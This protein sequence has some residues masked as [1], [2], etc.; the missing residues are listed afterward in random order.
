MTIPVWPSDLPQRSLSQAFQASTRGNRLTT[1][2]DT[3]PA[4]QRRRGPSVRPVTCAI[5][6]DMDGRALFD[7]FYEEGVGFGVT[8]F[9]IPDQQLDGGLL[10]DESWLL[11]EDEVGTPLIIESWWLVQFG[12]NQPATTAIDGIWFTIQFDLVV[13][14]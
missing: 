9:L 4:K 5:I 12:S 7:Q 1:A 3:G 2:T 14:P 11:L 8:P 6:V 13:L 10:N